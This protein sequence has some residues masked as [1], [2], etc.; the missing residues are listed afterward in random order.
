MIGCHCRSRALSLSCHRKRRKTQCFF[1]WPWV[2]SLCS[3]VTPS[4]ATTTGP[5]S[6]S[7]VVTAAHCLEQRLG[8]RATMLVLLALAFLGSERRGQQ[9]LVNAREQCWACLGKNVFNECQSVLWC[10]S[11]A[12]TNTMPFITRARAHAAGSPTT[13]A[14]SIH[15]GDWSTM[16]TACEGCDRGC[17]SASVL[18]GASYE[19]VGP[20]ENGQLGGTF[21]AQ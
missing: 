3:R 17:A 2:P 18:E 15:H 4:S 14:R 20:I 11:A 19:L 12:R 21:P 13:R 16:G 8:P 10:L 1:L 7:R 6:F 5:T 9:P